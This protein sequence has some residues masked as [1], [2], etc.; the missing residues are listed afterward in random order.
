MGKTNFQSELGISDASGT[1]VGLTLLRDKNGVPIY[2]EGFDYA[3]AQQFF[4][5]TSRDYTRY[6]ATRRITIAQ[7]D[8]TNGFGKEY[9]GSASRYHTGTNI[10]A[11]FPD[12]VRAGPLAT[13]I[14]LPTYPGTIPDEGFEIWTDANTLTHWT[15]VQDTGSP[16]LARDTTQRSGT[17]NAKITMPNASQFTLS[18]TL[19][20]NNNYR[21]KVINL[22]IWGYWSGIDATATVKIDDGVGNTTATITN[23]TPYA[24]ATIQRTMDSLATQLVVSI[25]CLNN[26][27]AAERILRLDDCWID[28]PYNNNVTSW[29]QFN[30]LMYM[31]C[32]KNLFK[33]D[34]TQAAFTYVDS[35]FR[36]IS[37]IYSTTHGGVD[38]LLILFNGW[39][40]DNYEMVAAE[41][42]QQSDLIGAE[43]KYITETNGTWWA[44]DTNSTTLS[45]INPLKG[46]TNW[47][48][49]DQIGEDTYDIV[50]MVTFEGLPYIKKSNGKVF[51]I[52]SAGAAKVLID[53][54]TEADGTD[55]AQMYVWRQSTLIIPQGNQGLVHYDGTTLTHIAPA[56]YMSNAT[57]FSGQVVAVTGDDMCLYIV[58]D[59]G[60]DVQIVSSKLNASAS[61][62][63]WHPLRT[64]TITACKSAFIGT[65]YKKRMW[66]GS[67]VGTESVNWIPVT[68][69][70]GDIANDSNYTYQTGGS[71]ETSYQTVDLPEDTK[72]WMKI[73]LRMSGTTSAIY[74][75]AYYWKLGDSSWTEMNATPTFFKTSPQTSAVFN[76]YASLPTSTMVKL[77]FEGV[78]NATATSPVLLG[79]KAEALWYPT[80]FKLITC[81]V[82]VDS[83]LPN[84]QGKRTEVLG[85]TIR[86][87]LDGINSSNKPRAFYP[88]YWR[89][90][91][92]TI[93]V[94]KLPLE[95]GLKLQKLEKGNANEGEQWYVYNLI[96]ER[97]S[98]S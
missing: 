20:W 63:G 73:T 93:Y 86:S 41:T 9:S 8:Y 10:D 25:T 84:A 48:N 75:R 66:V 68:T 12:E 61:D 45:T 23:I 82:L 76:D 67:T 7:Q 80:E 59:D 26:A 60:A 72:A 19:T 95:K 83:F 42:F 90:S 31:S 11:R 58:M 16:I 55:T 65:V 5:D 2:Y 40:Y 74:W 96:L 13:A 50:S 21:G 43:I 14:T 38:Y 54:V 39:D 97:Q 29:A 70:Y 46:G 35:F 44:S 32:G 91:A 69:K 98:V 36:E 49:S 15:F 89:T 30:S 17:Y 52:D 27:A 4:N 88:P 85:S 64:L 57:D 22:S 47:A 79:W 94:K 81:S 37:Q 56:L 62:W 34:A 33:A 53:G 24:K 92:D 1:E 71:I 28:A 18:R 3:Q 87:T 6:E 51:Y 77:K 78:T